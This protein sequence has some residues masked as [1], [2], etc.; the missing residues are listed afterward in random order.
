MIKEN[1]RLELTIRK[2]WKSLIRGGVIYID[3][4]NQAIHRGFTGTI[5]ARVNDGNHLIMINNG[6]AK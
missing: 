6:K 3:C 4:Y 1:N 2:H 5:S